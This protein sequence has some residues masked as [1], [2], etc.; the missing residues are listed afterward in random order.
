MYTNT[1]GK[2]AVSLGG[3]V[4][5]TVKSYNVTRKTSSPATAVTSNSKNGT[6][7]VAGALDWSAGCVFLSFIPPV[8][9]GEKTAFMGCQGI[10]DDTPGT[11]VKQ[12]GDVICTSIDI[13][14]C[15]NYC[16]T[17]DDFLQGG[18]LGK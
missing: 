11:S 9:P 4:L 17:T 8:I 3:S 5:S 14:T 6:L 18:L 10:N 1:G 16:T 15:T 2:A 12:S 13:T 7:A